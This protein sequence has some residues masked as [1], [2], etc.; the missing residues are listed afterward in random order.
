MGRFL[1]LLQGIELSLRR[2][3]FHE[4]Q[5]D[6]I[7]LFSSQQWTI[8]PKPS[9]VRLPGIREDVLRLK[10]SLSVTDLVFF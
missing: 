2:H 4:R 5:A 6:A 1:E 7:A 10:F 9:L 3:R 8:C